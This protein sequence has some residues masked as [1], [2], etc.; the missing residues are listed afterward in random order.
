MNKATHKKIEAVIT[1]KYERIDSEVGL[2]LASILDKLF[3]KIK[4]D[5]VLEKEDGK[6]MMY[7]ESDEV[8]LKTAAHFQK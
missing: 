5:R 6:W 1:R 7:N 2:M 8:L 3:R 4:I